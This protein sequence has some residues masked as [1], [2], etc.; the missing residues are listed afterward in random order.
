MKERTMLLIVVLI[1]VSYFSFF[2]PQAAAPV[3]YSFQSGVADLG[4]SSEGK[5]ID[6]PKGLFALIDDSNCAS[7]FPDGDC[8]FKSELNTYGNAQSQAFAKISAYNGIEKAVPSYV[9]NQGKNVYVGDIT[10]QYQC[11]GDKAYIREG[12]LNWYTCTESGC[13]GNTVSKSGS[14]TYKAPQEGLK[15]VRFQC[16]DYDKGTASNGDWS[17]S[18]VWAGLY[19]D[20]ND[21]VRLVT[22]PEDLDGDGV[23][24]DKDKCRDTATGTA[25]D[26][27]GCAVI[28][29]NPPPEEETQGETPS[30]GEQETPADQ[31]DGV[32]ETEGI[33]G[34][35]AFLIVA[36]MF[37][38]FL[39]IYT[40]KA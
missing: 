21:N 33:S 14:Y 27:E 12:N 8:Y 10:I 13:S 3:G 40:I 22:A 7:A 24:E 31:S 9:D 18:W 26:S 29:N 32:E 17:S 38:A 16:W 39:W 6:S 1:A 35:N 4:G 37:A 30:A 15:Q 23:T 28:T 11:Q 2:Q 34:W 25:V 19:Y 20:K 5:I 36:L